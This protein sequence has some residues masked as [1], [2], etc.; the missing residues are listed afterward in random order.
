MRR[1]SKS[2]NFYDGLSRQELINHIAQILW[3]AR[4]G[5]KR[6]WQG[7]GTKEKNIY[8]RVAEMMVT[9][10]QMR[11][12]SIRNQMAEEKWVSDRTPEKEVKRDPTALVDWEAISESLEEIGYRKVR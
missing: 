8:R 2:K 7:I 6:D 3:Y 1:N 4:P 12:T 10:T 5:A 11:V 9:E